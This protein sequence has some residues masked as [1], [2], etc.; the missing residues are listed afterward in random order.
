LSRT[1]ERG[2]DPLRG[3]LMN[4]SRGWGWRATELIWFAVPE[5]RTTNGYISISHIDEEFR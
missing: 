1:A 4:I 2:A 3:Q 5:K